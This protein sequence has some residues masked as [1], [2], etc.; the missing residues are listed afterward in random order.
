LRALP[1]VFGVLCSAAEA[2]PVIARVGVVGDKIFKVR[3]IL[4]HLQVVHMELSEA[5]SFNGMS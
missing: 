2:G 5:F 1:Q 4:A 3:G